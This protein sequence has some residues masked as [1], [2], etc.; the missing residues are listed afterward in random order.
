VSPLKLAPALTGAFRN[1]EVK[2][3]IKKLRMEYWSV[4]VLL[5]PELAK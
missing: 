4:V 3:E 1:G 2:D 5:H